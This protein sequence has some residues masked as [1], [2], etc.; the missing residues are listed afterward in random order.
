MCFKH[1]TDG[2]ICTRKGFCAVY[3]VSTKS[4]CC[5]RYFYS[6]HR[7]DRIPS[8]ARLFSLRYFSTDSPSIILLLLCYTAKCTPSKYTRARQK[9]YKSGSAKR[10]TAD[11]FDRHKTYPLS[12]KYT[13]QRT[14][15][16]RT[17][18]FPIRFR[19]DTCLRKVFPCAYIF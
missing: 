15:T 6:A 4:L 1:T 5:T 17:T 14:S 11:T 8:C 10:P 16:K 12:F 7:F 2:N 13:R 3:N 18:K 19:P 9:A